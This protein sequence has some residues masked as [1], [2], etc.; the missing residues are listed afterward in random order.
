M[1]TVAVLVNR[2]VVRDE[3]GQDLI[4]YALLVALIAIVAITGVSAMG[5]VVNNV[6]WRFVA[7]SVN[8]I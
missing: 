7:A 2:L 3:T 5:N 1:E 6:L 4:E 8:G